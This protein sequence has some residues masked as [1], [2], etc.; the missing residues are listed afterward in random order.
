MEPIFDA[1]K[2]IPCL[3]IEA[4]RTHRS[5]LNELYAS[6]E[7]CYFFA[8]RDLKIRYKQAAFGIGWAV[9]RPLITMAFFTLIFGKIANLPSDNVSYPLFVLVG[10]I[11]WQLVATISQDSSIVLLTQ[12]P[13]ITKIY[14]PRM[15]IPIGVLVVNLFDF[16]ICYALFFFGMWITGTPVY[17]TILFSPLLIVQALLLSLG[18]SF[19]CSALTVRYRDF[20]FVVALLVQFSLLFSPIGYTTTLIAEPW[21]WLYSL[22]PLVG[23]IDGLRWATF[24]AMTPHLAYSMVASLGLTLLL[25]FTGYW[26]FRRMER[27]IADTL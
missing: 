14:F 2:P 1:Q 19:W 8:W 10:M 27:T 6:R 25:L 21:S 20:R 22:N 3:L 15:V 11:V 24:Q 9:V 17:W 18:L 13:I 7:L 12:A 23:I 26:Y 4:S 16:L 5:Y